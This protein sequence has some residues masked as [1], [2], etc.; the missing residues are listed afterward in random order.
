MYLGIC[1][2]GI[3]AVALSS[4]L[5]VDGG[6]IEVDNTNNV[7][8]LDGKP[9]KYVGGSIHYFRLPNE[10]WRD[11]LRRIK[12]LGFNVV[13][14]YI[15][16]SLHEIEPGVYDFEGDKDFEKFVRTAQEEGL[17]VLIRP[18]PYLSSERDFG[19][20]PGWLLN[21]NPNMVVR[22]MDSA[23][24]YYLERWLTVAFERINP[25][26][27]GNGGP[28]LMVQV[29]NEYGNYP[30]ND[31]KYL[32]W[33]G[34][35]MRSQVGEKALLYQTDNFN[36]NAL[37]KSHLPDVLSTVDF[38]CSGA[39]MANRFSALRALQPHGPLVNSEFYTGEIFFWSHPRH[40]TSVQTVI[41]TMK[42]M[43]NANVSFNL[44][45]VYG[46]TNFGFRAGGGLATTYYYDIPLTEFGDLTEKYTA[47]R[48][49]LRQY[50]WTVG[51]DE[52]IA[53]ISYVPKGSY[54]TVSLQPA[55]SLLDS[56]VG[57]QPVSTPYP[58]HMEAFKQYYG[59]I[60][61]SHVIKTPLQDP[62]VLNVF[63]RDRSIVLVDNEPIAQLVYTK[64]NTTSLP[65]SVKQGSKLTI[66]VENQGRK[67]WGLFDDVIKGISGNVTIDGQ[68]LQD[69][70][71]VNYPMEPDDVKKVETL[72]SSN[73]LAKTIRPPA[74][75]TANFTIPFPPKVNPDGTPQA[76]YQTCL[77]MT[78]WG[79]GF[80]W[81]NGHNLGRY[82]YVGPQM[83][84]YVPGV[85]L[86]PVPQVNTITI[87]ELHYVNPDLTVNFVP[88]HIYIA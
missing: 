21:I 41:D 2:I 73:A 22:T 61:Y 23:F 79:K 68:V 85:W 56:P 67:Y 72:A 11:R 81:I 47:I 38:G 52:E 19:G 69:W 80:V 63:A 77:D 54:G 27:Y 74:F 25:L 3:L 18:G 51:S 8:L 16:W 13:S 45:T 35:F 49:L 65:P 57:Y 83:T 64:T 4:T 88:E 30:I 9:F 33:L 29:E 6:T 53:N 48:N 20:F 87:F 10:Y 26:L 7:F 44:Y 76:P 82:W 60:A 70:E 75:Y 5:Q 37:S 58:L 40:Y 17:Y 84:L 78:G 14:T 55:V 36:A 34:N 32:T 1:A 12:L 43:L 62:S 24:I 86:K 71:T 42:L 39:S 15:E 28:I 31:R 59:F 46:G 66:L 50:N